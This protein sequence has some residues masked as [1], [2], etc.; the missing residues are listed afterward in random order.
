LPIKSSGDQPPLALVET[1]FLSSTACLLCLIGNYLPMSK[2]FLKPFL[3]LPIAFVY[4][5]LGKRA[6]WMSVVVTSLLLLILAGPDNSILFTI[7]N[8]LLGIQI[9]AFWRRRISWGWSIF[10]GGILDTFGLFF[11]LHLTSIMTGEYLWD[12]ATKRFSDILNW[13]LEKSSILA[14]PSDWTIQ[15][16]MISVLFISGLPSLLM[17]HCAALLLFKRIGESIKK[18][19]SMDKKIVRNLDN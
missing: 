14:E 11:R 4:L 1:A 2:Q 15:L 16:V 9:G 10:V 3:A 6:G 12:Y 17:T 18:P 7:P 5:R 19:T 8:G 13:V